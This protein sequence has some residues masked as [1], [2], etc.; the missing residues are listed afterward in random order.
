MQYGVVILSNL[1]LQ[2]PTFL[3]LIVGIIFALATWKRNPRPALFA[4]I[5]FS[6]TFLLL[7]VGSMTTI[8]PILLDSRYNLPISQI[9]IISTVLNVVLYLFHAGALGLII[10]AIFTGRKPVAV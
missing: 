1:A 5:G 4:L 2:I 9:A 3:A 8:L 10:A 6:L 7:V